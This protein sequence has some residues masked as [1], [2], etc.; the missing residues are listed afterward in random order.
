[1]RWFLSLHR[2]LEPTQAELAERVDRYLGLLASRNASI[3]TFA[4]EAVGTLDA[5]DRLPPGRLVSGIVPALLSR[6]KGTV[7]KALG[8]LDHAVHRDPSVKAR[9]AAVAVEALAHESPAVHKAVLDWIERHG[10]EAQP[11]V[12]DL[13]RARIDTVAASERARLAG[14]LGATSGTASPD[15]STNDGEER[16]LFNRAS[17]IEP[18]IAEILLHHRAGGDRQARAR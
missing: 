15:A 16:E 5:A 2:K 3:A 1:M 4:L 8:Y 12:V 7:L 14:W 17:A 6:T 13:L 9:A 11:E 18:S 10:A